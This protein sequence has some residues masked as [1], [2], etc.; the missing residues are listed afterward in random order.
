MVEARS[1]NVKK[2]TKQQSILDAA[3]E[4]GRNSV[5]KHQVQPEYRDEQFSG[6]SGDREIFVFPVELT[7]S[8]IGNLTRL[9]LTLA[10]YLCI[11]VYYVMTPYRSSTCVLY[12]Q[13]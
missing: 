1:V 3:A 4:I 8:R 11:Y 9:I 7:T 13:Q 2:T 5:S 6:A 12:L 10:T